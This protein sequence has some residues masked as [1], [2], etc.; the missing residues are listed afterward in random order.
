[1]HMHKNNLDDIVSILGRVI[2]LT[3]MHSDKHMYSLTPIHLN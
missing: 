1:M 3:G 2:V